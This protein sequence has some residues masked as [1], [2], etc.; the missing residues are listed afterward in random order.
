MLG[1]NAQGYFTAAA[2]V[3]RSGKAGK[4]INQ[5][6]EQVGI[7]KRA[8]ALKR[9]GQAL[10]PGPCVNIFLLQKSQLAVGLPVEL[11]KDK[12][13][14]LQVTVAVAAGSAV[15]IAAARFRTQVVVDFGAGAAGPSGTDLP[16]IIFFAQV[17]YPLRGDAHTL[18]PYVV[19][20]IILLVD[21]NPELFRR[22]AEQFSDKLPGPFNGFF[23]KII[24]KREVAKHFEKSGMPAGIAD[25]LNIGSAHAFLAGGNASMGRLSLAAEKR[26]QRSH[27]RTD[28]EQR[29]IVVG[30]QRK[31]GHHQVPFAG[32]KI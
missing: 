16:K 28:E 21:A 5:G 8:R 18:P 19:G 11:G 7:V 12:V 25:P 14:D 1:D 20:F 23:L 17:D 4:I 26:F 27:A 24:A 30:D 13:P 9:R 15:L 2:G 10:Q 31:T 32:K 22:Q 29:R 6:L 3:C